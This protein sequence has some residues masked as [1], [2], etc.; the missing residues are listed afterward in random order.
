[1]IVRDRERRNIESLLVL[2]VRRGNLDLGAF[3]DDVTLALECIVIHAL[4]T[5]EKELLDVGLRATSFAADGRAVTRRIAPAENIQ[6]LFAHNPLEDAF[7][8]QAV[9]LFYGEK[10]HARR[11]LAG[12]RKVEAQLC[13]L[14][15]KKLMGDLDQHAGAIA[16]LCDRIRTRRDASD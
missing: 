3:A 12:S 6:T 16:R 11:V 5:A 13:A 8:L 15:H 2:N 7:A 1:M 14:P 10:N 9:L 4:R